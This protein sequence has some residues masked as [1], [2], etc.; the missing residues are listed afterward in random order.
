ME[1]AV[2]LKVLLCFIAHPFPTSPLFPARLGP[3][4]CQAH[5]IQGNREGISTNNAQFTCP[6]LSVFPIPFRRGPELLCLPREQ[7]FPEGCSVLGRFGLELCECHLTNIVGAEELCSSSSKS[8]DIIHSPAVC[9]W[10]CLL[11][12]GR[13]RIPGEMGEMPWHCCARDGIC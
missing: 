10:C 12:E 3:Q 2:S 5:G 13:D 7:E 1:I 8:C 11:G 4:P 9:D 6:F